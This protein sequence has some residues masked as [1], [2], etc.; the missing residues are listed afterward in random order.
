MTSL[1]SGTVYVSGGSYNTLTYGVIAA[2]GTNATNIKTASATLYSAHFYNNNTQLPRFVKLYNSSVAPTAGTT[3]AFTVGVPPGDFRDVEFAGA[4]S[5][6][7]L[8]Y[9]ITGAAPSTDT[10]AVTSNDIIGVIEYV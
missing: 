6:Q 10:T 5:S 8:G 7:G 9:T 4:I 2:S 1:T 3:P